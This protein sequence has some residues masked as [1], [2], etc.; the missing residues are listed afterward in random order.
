MIEEWVKDARNEAKVKA[1]LRTKANKAMGV[2][3][4]DNQEL[5]TKLTA[6]ERVGKSAEANLK[7]AHNQA[8]DQRKKLYHTKIELAIKK[9]QV[10]ELKTELQRAKEVA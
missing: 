8:E 7:N 6:E 1:N 4:Q 9:Q 2:A 3:K 5:A 10:L